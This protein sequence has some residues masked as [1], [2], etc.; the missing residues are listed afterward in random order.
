[1]NRAVTKQPYAT[2]RRNTFRLPR[3]VPGCRTKRACCAAARYQRDHS[4]ARWDTNSVAIVLASLPTRDSKVSSSLTLTLEACECIAY[5]SQRDCFL[6]TQV[7]APRTQVGTIVPLLDIVLR[8]PSRTLTLL[9]LFVSHLHFDDNKIEALEC[10]E[11]DFF[12]LVCD[13]A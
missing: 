5:P 7:I 6:I 1:M 13:S 3:S 8:K 9:F 2:D 11:R 12:K 4:V 10:S